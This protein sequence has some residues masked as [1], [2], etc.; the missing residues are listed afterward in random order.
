MK[1]LIVQKSSDKDTA[2]ISNQKDQ[3]DGEYTSAM[4]LEYM[5]KSLPNYSVKW[6]QNSTGTQQLEVLD[7]LVLS[8]GYDIQ[9]AAMSGVVKCAVFTDNQT[10]LQKRQE[11]AI[12]KNRGAKLATPA[13]KREIQK[14]A[15]NSKNAFKKKDTIAKCPQPKTSTAVKV[16]NK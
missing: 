2:V 9:Q 3:N 5:E 7:S 10:N 11:T 1:N 6:C 14:E 13:S 15:R 4:A 8:K 16:N 12:M